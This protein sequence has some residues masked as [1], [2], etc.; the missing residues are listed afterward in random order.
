MALAC[1]VAGT[2][3]DIE[4]AAGRW[5]LGINGAAHSQT[6]LAIE[7]HATRRRAIGAGHADN[8]GGYRHA[9][10]VRNALP[11]GKA[12]SGQFSRMEVDAKTGATGAATLARRHRGFLRHAPRLSPDRPR[13][14]AGRGRKRGTS[15]RTGSVARR[16]AAMLPR[17]PAG[18]WRARWRG[19]FHR[20]TPTSCCGI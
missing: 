18:R 4:L 2:V 19:P 11:P 5:A 15:S 8:A 14:D 7:C 6:D 9:Q 1:P 13:R 16:T 3:F 17:P 12:P 20:Y 10:G